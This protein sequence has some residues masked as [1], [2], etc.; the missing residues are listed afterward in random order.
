MIITSDVKK[1][2]KYTVM[3]IQRYYQILFAD[4]LK[5]TTEVSHQVSGHHREKPKHIS[6][7]ITKSYLIICVHKLAVF[8]MMPLFCQKFYCMRKTVNPFFMG[9][10]YLQT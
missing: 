3:P 8:E 6:H 4:E 9:I 1:E 5:Q 10:S 2:E 7:Y